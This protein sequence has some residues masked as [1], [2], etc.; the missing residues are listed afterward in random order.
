[1]KYLVLP[2]RSRRQKRDQ[3]YL[4]CKIFMQS[5]DPVSKSFITAVPA[6]HPNTYQFDAVQR[7]E[8]TSQ[9]LVGD[10]VR[11]FKPTFWTEDWAILPR[12]AVDRSASDLIGARISRQS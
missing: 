2:R 4:D 7:L 9:A 1:M 12:Q 6:E 3:K 10:T 8:A 11:S 5:H